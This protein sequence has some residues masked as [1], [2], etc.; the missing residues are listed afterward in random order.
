MSKFSHIPI[1]LTYSEAMYMDSLYYDNKSVRK[2]SSLLN[3][4]EEVY[5]TDQVIY[6]IILFVEDL[7]NGEEKD[8]KKV[9]QLL[10][11]LNFKTIKFQTVLSLL[12]VLN[13]I[14]TTLQNFKEFHKECKQ[15]FDA[16]DYDSG[17][18]FKDL[19]Y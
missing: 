17:K 15:Y 5:T 13:P 12:T 1:E 19:G 14:H 6:L 4:L 2:R 10:S 7:M 3:Q 16:Q 9:N 8:L 11:L 18:I